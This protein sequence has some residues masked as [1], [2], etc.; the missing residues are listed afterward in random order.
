MDHVPTHACAYCAAGCNACTDRS[1]AR[2]L[3][4][5]EELWRQQIFSTATPSLA[6]HLCCCDTHAFAIIRHCSSNNTIRPY[7]R[8]TLRRLTCAQCNAHAHIT[9]RA[10]CPPS[11]RQR[12][13]RSALHRVCSR[14]RTLKRRVHRRALHRACSRAHT[15]KRV[16]AATHT[17]VHD[18]APPRARTSMRDNDH[19]WARARTRSRD[20]GHARGLA[21]ATSTC[22]QPRHAR[23]QCDTAHSHASP[24]PHRNQRNTH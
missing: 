11:E 2:P 8:A 20:C 14:V 24:V 6:R 1:H 18:H 17:R 22:V 19:A 4:I 23:E 5:V 21:V 16:H 10:T 9:Q 15:R 3:R 7:A 12:V 13:R